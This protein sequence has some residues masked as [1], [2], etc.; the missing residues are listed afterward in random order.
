MIISQFF[1]LSELE[2]SAVYAS[3][4]YVVFTIVHELC[5]ALSFG[6]FF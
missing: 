1:M 5:F 3:M 4:Y 6:S 2:E